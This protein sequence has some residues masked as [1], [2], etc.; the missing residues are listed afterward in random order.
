MHEYKAISETPRK[1]TRNKN[2][3]TGNGIDK[4]YLK[5]NISF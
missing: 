5:L 2:K 1:Q 3:K 4:G